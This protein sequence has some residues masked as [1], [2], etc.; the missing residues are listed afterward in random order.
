[1]Y[2]E[3]NGAVPA[4]TPE[5]PFVAGDVTELGPE[6]VADAVPNRHAEA[7]RKGAHRVHELIRLGRLYEQEHGLKRGRQRLRQLIA[8]GRQ[9]EQDHGLRVARPRRPRRADSLKALLGALLRI[10]KPA[11]RDELLAMFETLERGA[12]KG[13]EQMDVPQRIGA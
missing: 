7:G 1:M 2:D 13:A 8:E 11:Y 4:P 6:P 10:A 9:Y 12:T 5:L 3:N